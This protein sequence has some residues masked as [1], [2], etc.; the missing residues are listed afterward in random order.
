MMVIIRGKAP[1]GLT[2][3]QLRHENTHYTMC[4]L[5]QFRNIRLQI[6]FIIPHYL[7]NIFDLQMSSA[8]L[9]DFFYSVTIHR[10]FPCVQVIGKKILGQSIGNNFSFA[11]YKPTRIW[12]STQYYYDPKLIILSEH[13]GKWPPV[14]LLPVIRKQF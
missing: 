14:I 7:I 3:Q 12:Y 6:P 1:K 8:F 13:V 5:L 2:V 11:Y 9:C 4:G 10:P